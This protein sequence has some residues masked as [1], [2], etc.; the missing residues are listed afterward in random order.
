MTDSSTNFL[1]T[2]SWGAIDQ[3]PCLRLV[4]IV[5]EDPG[6]LQARYARQAWVKVEF[7]MYA[8]LFA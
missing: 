4:S 3:Y 6:I 2:V 5:L 8:L 1:L 7:R